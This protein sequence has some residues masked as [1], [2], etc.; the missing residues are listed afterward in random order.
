MISWL[1][2]TELSQMTNEIREGIAVW[3]N[4]P[5][6]ASIAT[7]LSL[8]SRFPSFTFSWSCCE[9]IGVLRYGGFN[10]VAFPFLIWLNQ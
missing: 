1:A 4:Q 2:Q 10:I 7:V 5:T 6:C 3:G 9:E 8:G